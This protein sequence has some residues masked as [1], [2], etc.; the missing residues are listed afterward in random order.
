METEFIIRVKDQ[1]IDLS[2]VKSVKLTNS[3]RSQN[4]KH[5]LEI[6]L[7]GQLYYPHGNSEPPEFISDSI[8]IHFQNENEATEELVEI[9]RIWDKIAKERSGG[10]GPFV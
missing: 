10:I 7:K 5:I 2:Q 9:A 1:L 4:G 6:E 8:F 3:G